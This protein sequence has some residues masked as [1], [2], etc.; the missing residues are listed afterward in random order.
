MEA[1]GRGS[2]WASYRKAEFGSSRAQTYRFLDVARA[3]AAIHGAVAAGTEAS[4]TR[5]TAPTAEA[6]LDHDLSQRVL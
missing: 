1:A 5:D 3:L 4:R 6:A 2:S